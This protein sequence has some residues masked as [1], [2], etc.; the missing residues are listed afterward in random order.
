MR[1]NNRLWPSF[2]VGCTPAGDNQVRSCVRLI[3]VDTANATIAQDFDIGIS[4]K[5]LFYPA[6]RTDAAG[7]LVVVFGHSSATE[8]PD[9]RVATRSVHDPPNTIGAP[10]VIRAGEGPEA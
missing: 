3:E 5:Y 1:A 10:Q 8:Y 7:N 2:D 9:M 6:L 4:G